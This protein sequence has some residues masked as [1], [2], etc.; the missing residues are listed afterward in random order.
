MMKKVLLSLLLVATGFIAL[1][2]ETTLQPAI[3]FSETNSGLEV[4]ITCFEEAELY[5]DDM[6]VGWIYDEYVYLY[7]VVQTSE[8]RIITVTAYAQALD[9]LPSPV[10]T[11]TYE[12]PPVPLEMTATPTLNCIAQD[13]GG[14]C[15]VTITN[16]DSDLSATIFYSYEVHNSGNVWHSDWTIYD[17]EPI[18]FNE[19]GD[20]YFTAYAQ[21]DG[22]EPSDIAYMEFHVDARC[23]MPPLIHPVAVTQANGLQMK[24]IPD[25]LYATGD[26]PEYHSFVNA[27]VFYYRINGGAE[28]S[29]DSNGGTISLPEYGQYTITACGHS[30]GA[31]DSQIITAIIDYDETGYTT[32]SND[33]MVHD[34]IIYTVEDN[35]TLS[36]T[37]PGTPRPGFYLPYSGAIVIPAII[38]IAGDD[39][40]VEAIGDN[41]FCDCDGLTLISI[42]ASVTSVASNAFNGC[43]GL[44]T[45]ICKATTPPNA[46]NASGE[47]PMIHPNMTLYVPAQALYDYRSHEFWNMFYRIEAMEEQTPLVLFD[48]SADELTVTVF[49]D[50]IAEVNIDGRNVGPCDGALIYKIPR[51]SSDDFHVLVYIIYNN[52]AFYFGYDSRYS[53]FATE[54]MLYASEVE[55]GKGLKIK[56]GADSNNYYN[57]F[58][59]TDGF[60][61]V[62]PEYCDYSINGSSDW[63]RAGMGD[64]LYLPDYGDYTIK[65]YGVAG[66]DECGNSPTINIVVHYGPDGFYSRSNSY[67]VYNGLYFSNNDYS[68]NVTA[69]LGTNNPGDDLLSL[70]ALS[71]MVIPASFVI[72]GDEYTVT[73]VSRNNCTAANSITCLSVTPI[74]AWLS[75]QGEGDPFFEQVKLFVPQEGLEAYKADPEWGLFTHIAPFIGAGPG[76]INGDGT[77]AIGDVTTLI[78]LLL[79]GGELP[80]Y[81]DV[82]GDGEVSINDITILIDAL[83]AQ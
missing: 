63:T 11:A 54:P 40:T 58:F 48:E 29:M 16:D 69:H 30:D 43:N 55:Q 73:H 28:L 38:S 39:Y 77:I 34:G 71:D 5:V 62:W 26:N 51:R 14:P 20:Y 76:D 17:G 21:S 15:Y 31:A 70:P 42:P 3:Y 72:A 67:I 68:N 83:L 7:P 19:A 79:Y 36:V 24:L 74:E 32:L 46:T 27:D 8:P 1:A 59:W 10:T 2:Q 49:T 80:A 25:P 13:D 22:K 65:A 75:G 35:N 64:S 9:K 50:G 56:I 33:V 12:I 82:N 6:D 18:M 81:A 57:L 53:N 44:K 45:I 37:A 4:H 60:E 52:N 41:A 66:G 23:V 47:S 78:E 61:H